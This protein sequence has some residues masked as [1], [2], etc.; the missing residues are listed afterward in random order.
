MSHIRRVQREN[1]RVDHDS[2]HF[3]NRLMISSL[4]DTVLNLLFPPV[5]RAC[6]EVH[7]GNHEVILC[8][9]CTQRMHVL[10]LD[11]STKDEED[12]AL[13]SKEAAST[14][15]RAL[16]AVA[17]DTPFRELI[18]EFKFRGSEKV[19]PLLIEWF[20]KGA[21]EHLK[22]KDFDVIV[23][24]PLHWWRK[25]QREFNQAEVLGASLAERWSVPMQTSALRR[26][27]QTFPQ[28]RLK[29]KWRARNIEGAFVPGKDAVKGQRVLLVDDVMTTGATLSACAEVLIKAGASCV[30]GFTLAKRM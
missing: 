2:N 24:V 18:H 5:C 22:R 4:T 3:Q 21:E 15:F 23:P 26:V 16:S 27:R 13:L 7:P 14:P 20:L 19:R 12:L 6:G 11:D 29:G 1:S 28:S 8:D 17:Y 10:S 25:F 30:T 9:T